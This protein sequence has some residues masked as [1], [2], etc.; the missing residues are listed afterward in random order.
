MKNIQ[1]FLLAFVFIFISNNSSTSS[2]RLN[3]IM[4]EHHSCTKNYHIKFSCTTTNNTTIDF[5]K[6]ESTLKFRKKAVDQQYQDDISPEDVDEWFKFK[7]KPN[8]TYDMDITFIAKGRNLCRITETP[9][10]T[11][12]VWAEYFMQIDNDIE[13]VVF[14]CDYKNNRF[15]LH[16]KDPET[17]DPSKHLYFRPNELYYPLSI[18]DDLDRVEISDNGDFIDIAWKSDDPESYYV[19]IEATLDPQYNFLSRKTLVKTR[20]N[21]N[22]IKSIYAEQNTFLLFEKQ[23]FPSSSTVV[24]FAQFEPHVKNQSVNPESQIYDSDFDTT[25]KVIDIDYLKKYDDKYV[26]KLKPEYLYHTT[27]R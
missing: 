19:S 27:N 3:K 6:H 5:S 25:F 16:Q 12:R 9:K 18:I 7:M 8:Q 13:D 14:F 11:Y 1:I 17:D 10:L 24:C 4:N 15:S 22:I 2:E 20:E 26:L 23:Y 21:E